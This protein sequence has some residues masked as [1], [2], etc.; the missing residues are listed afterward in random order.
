MYRPAGRGGVA[1]GRFAG[2]SNERRGRTAARPNIDGRGALCH[3]L[4]RVSLQTSSTQ[5][6]KH[7]AEQR[8]LHK[9]RYATNPSIWTHSCRPPA[10]PAPAGTRRRTRMILLT[11]ESSPLPSVMVASLQGRQEQQESGGSEHQSNWSPPR[12]RRLP[13][14][15]P[16]EILLLKKSWATHLGSPAATAIAFER[17]G[18]DCSLE[19]SSTTV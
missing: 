7:V 8:P 9:R 17:A 16:E 2:F 3:H 18:L 13:Q 19:A 4:Q 15:C 10:P 14:Q 12:T 1:A 11:T 6:K 5:H